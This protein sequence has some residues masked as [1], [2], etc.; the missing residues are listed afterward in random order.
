MNDS[1]IS[2]HFLFRRGDT[3]SPVVDGLP[4]TA[5][6]TIVRQKVDTLGRGKFDAKYVVAWVTG[7]HAGSETI[8]NQAKLVLLKKNK[9]KP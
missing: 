3:V 6:G 4:G 9:V 5:T 8:E 1:T 2:P 7:P